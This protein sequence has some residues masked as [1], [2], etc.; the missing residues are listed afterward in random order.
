VLCHCHLRVASLSLVCGGGLVP[1]DT[2][3]QA[4][5]KLKHE[6]LVMLTRKWLAGYALHDSVLQTKAKLLELL[7]AQH[8]C[9][10]RRALQIQ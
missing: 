3:R 10:Y 1:M 8:V 4:L 5:N 9:H 2:D 6:Q 7:V